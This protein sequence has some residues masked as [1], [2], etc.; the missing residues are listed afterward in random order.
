MIF[1][2]GD[3]IMK[4]FLGLFLILLTGCAGLFPSPGLSD[5]NPGSLT[6]MSY[7]IHTG[8]GSDGLFSL[9]RIVEDIQKA[10]ADLVGIQEMDRF[11]KRN[12]MDQAALLERLSGFHILFAKNLD[13]QGGEYGIAVLSRFP[14]V[15]HRIFHYQT[16]EAREPRGVLAVK[17]QPFS[18]PLS[19]SVWFVTTHLGTDDTGEEQTEQVKQLTDW[20]NALP[21]DSSLIVSGDF[22]QR[23]DSRAVRFFSDRFA[24]LWTLKGIG[25]GYTYPATRPSSRI[26]YLFVKTGDLAE[27]RDVTVMETIASDHRPVTARI[28]VK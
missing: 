28:N 18:N 24:D 2:K 9:E 25:K 10:N 15:E 7:N 23:P 3:N 26:D 8:K 27:C 1:L 14:I 4:R 22:N 6:A 16:W 20:L 13:Y 12:P 21:G 17:V 19:R 5:R 11:T